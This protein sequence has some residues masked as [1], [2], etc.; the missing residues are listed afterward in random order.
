[1]R[2]ACRNAATGGISVPFGTTKSPW[3]GQRPEKD[4]PGCILLI[5]HKVKI[6]FHV[7]KHDF[8]CKVRRSSKARPTLPHSTSWLGGA[9]TAPIP[10]PGRHRSLRDFGSRLTSCASLSPWQRHSVAPVTSELSEITRSCFGICDKGTQ[11]A[12]LGWEQ[13][14]HSPWGLCS[15]PCFPTYSTSPGHLGSCSWLQELCRLPGS[16]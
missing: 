11:R 16:H 3:K 9:V 8:L 1:M 7:K 14:D 6:S 10:R 5:F 4:G 13:D 2:L 12:R 15:L